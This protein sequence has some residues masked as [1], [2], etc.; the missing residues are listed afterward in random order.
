M[1]PVRPLLRAAVKF[2][3]R[4]KDGE[5]RHGVTQQLDLADLLYRAR[6]LAV[7]AGRRANDLETAQSEI[8]GFNRVLE[9]RKE[10]EPKNFMPRTSGCCRKSVSQPW[11]KSLRPWRTSF[12]T[13]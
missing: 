1:V 2:F 10:N 7:Q 12:E 6:R 9:D 5:L 13:H 3:G 8:R 4:H 11:D